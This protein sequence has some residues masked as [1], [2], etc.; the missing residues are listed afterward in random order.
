M[1]LE[2]NLEEG[3]VGEEE[4][5]KA[6]KRDRRQRRCSQTLQEKSVSNAQLGFQQLKASKEEIIK[7]L[8]SALIFQLY[9]NVNVVFV[10]VCA[11]RSL[12]S[13]CSF[14]RSS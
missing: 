2:Q 3:E 5:E 8:Q 13:C 12:L 6:I 14:C 9:R 11:P 10:R 1:K 7:R 4:K